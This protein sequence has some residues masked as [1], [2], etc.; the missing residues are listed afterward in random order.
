MLTSIKRWIAG[1]GNPDASVEV[2]SAWGREHGWR[3]ARVDDGATVVLAEPREQGSTHIEWGPV[4]D[5]GLGLLEL[6]LRTQLDC[7]AGLQLL[8]LSM[9]VAEGWEM[10]AAKAMAAAPGSRI[11]D[12]PQVAATE[13]L[14]WLTLLPR[15]GA[16]RMPAALR[17]SV[18]AVASHVKLGTDWLHNGLAPVLGRE[19]IGLTVSPFILKLHRGRLSLRVAA[20]GVSMAS[21]AA[22]LIVHESA[23]QSA[24]HVSRS[25]TDL[26]DWPTT[27]SA[28]WHGPVNTGYGK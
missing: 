18:V 22:A 4:P 6:R 20:P 27:A 25:L 16:T 26:G 7:P 9:G 28:A 3:V 10:A 8:V 2:L 11:G 12:L 23:G 13:E 5:H 15:I 17:S 14:N 19:E 21:L 24:V 1:D